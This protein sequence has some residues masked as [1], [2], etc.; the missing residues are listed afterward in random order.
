MGN[1][2]KTSVDSWPKAPKCEGQGEISAELCGRRHPEW[3][4]SAGN[5][6]EIRVNSC[7]LGNFKE[8]IREELS[9]WYG[10]GNSL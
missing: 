2:W 1:K 5:K 7:G 8:R 4:T 6:W 9:S 10:F 3:E